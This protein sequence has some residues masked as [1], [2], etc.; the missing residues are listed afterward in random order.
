MGVSNSNGSNPFPAACASAFGCAFAFALAGPAACAGACLCA[1]AGSRSFMRIC[2]LRCTQRC[3]CA[4]AGKASC[5]VMS[6]L[7]LQRFAMMLQCC[8]VML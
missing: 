1:G 7:P 2:V 8:A 4:G 5:I 6:T 3:M